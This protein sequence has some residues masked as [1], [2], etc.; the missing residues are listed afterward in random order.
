MTPDDPRHGKYAGYN[1]GCRND[2][3]RSAAAAYQ[4]RRVH[5]S[6]HGKPRSVD[7]TGVRRRIRALTRI[8]HNAESIGMAAGLSAQRIN[9][10]ARFTRLIQRSTHDRIVTAYNHLSATPG[11]SREAR[12]H[13]IRLAY[14]SPLAWDDDTI[15]DPAAKPQGI[16]FSR[17]R[18]VIDEAAIER[19]IHGDRNVKL[20]KGEAAEVVRRL[21][22]D[23]WPMSRIE[24]H[25]GVNAARYITSDIPEDARETEEVA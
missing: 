10:L 21:R 5:E 9:Q 2:C 22:A 24:E 12:K 18:P 6:R 11:T 20:H 14:S 25:T 1:A 13:G 8:G 3:C 15:D 4:K 7:P 16:D 17:A 23:G 19:R